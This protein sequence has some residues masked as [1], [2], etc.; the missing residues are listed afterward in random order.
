M[1]EI[2]ERGEGD[3]QHHGA[4]PL[5]VTTLN[6]K[7]IV[8]VVGILAVTI[9]VVSY[10]ITPVSTQRTPAEMQNQISQSELGG[11]AQGTYFQ[12]PPD[13]ARPWQARIP[14][15]PVLTPADP[16]TVRPSE[17]P[18]S[19]S[20]TV[21]PQ[22]FDAYAYSGTVYRAEPSYGTYSGSVRPGELPQKSESE[23]A[24]ER[25]MR[26]GVRSCPESGEEA[27]P[28]SYESI[29]DPQRVANAVAANTRAIS[30]TA[31]PNAAQSGQTAASAPP[32]RYRAFLESAGG[33]DAPTY[34][35]ARIQE[36]ISPYQI[37]AG[38]MIPVTLLTAINSDMPGE[39][40][41]QVTRNIYD[42]Q[43]RHLLI[44][45]GSRFLGKVDPD[46]AM[47]QSRVNIGWYRLIFPNNNSISL[48]ALQGMDREGTTGI[49]DR[50]N[51]HYG[52]TYLHALLLSAISAGMQL[53][54]PRRGGS[55]LS[56]PSTGEVAAGAIGQQ[57]GQVSTET[58]RQQMNTSPT[59]EV[60]QGFQ[61]YVYVS[62][63][64]VLEP[65]EFETGR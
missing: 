27:A 33:S 60:R 28:A 42:T 10:F 57:M 9:M 24:F 34:I 56:T 46:V 54:Q 1:D 44:P 36:P 14:P 48:P 64:L 3:R 43:Q 47:G 32:D 50:V 20:G 5:R 62:R 38:T 18:S 61:F 39:V 35:P 8:A 30:G 12:N 55:V 25:A 49:R 52:R 63:D 11:S 58:I 6:R 7:A 37:M 29:L 15:R 23:L 13:T 16:D 26:C 65:Y 31:L 40:I 41:A 53:S 19:V 17:L 4:G 21:P 22:P 2:P 51:N 45:A 59:L